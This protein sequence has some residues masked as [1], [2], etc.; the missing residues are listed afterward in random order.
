MEN[1]KT[2][3]KE[4]SLSGIGLHTGNKVNIKFKPAGIDSGIN[5][6]RV[7]LPKKENIL[8]VADNLL[9]ISRN[10]RRTSIG[11]GDVEI[12]TIEHIMAV[13]F[14][15]S[16]DNINIEIDNNEVP[17]LDGSGQDFLEILTN[18]GIVEQAKPRNVYQIKEAICI[19]EDGSS[20][21][22][23]PSSG[24]KVSYTLKYS[25]PKIDTQFLDL[26]INTESFQKEL[27]KSRT[28]CL[29]EEAEDLKQQG[30]GRGANYE[31]TLVVGKNGV[32]KNKLRYE[33][34]YVRHKV[35]DLIGDLYLMGSSLKGHIV[36]LR[37]GH[38]LNIKLLG[39]IIEQRA[40]FNIG[41]VGSSG[42][43]VKEGELDAEEIKKILPHRYPFL[44]VDKILHLEKGKRA[45]GLKNV[46]EDDYYF[47]GHFPGKPVMP[48][49]LIIEAMAQV[50]GVMMLSLAQNKG[51]LAYFLA[52][53]NVKFRKTVLPG[54]KLVLEVEVGKLKSKTGLVHSRALVGSKVVAEADLM[55]AIAES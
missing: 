12:H 20:I 15:L 2:I 19:E 14:G 50:G 3:T 25:H 30:L 34:E 1:Q 36:A 17:G 51:K 7:D 44:F 35:L 37:S 10:P 6:I 33:D 46:N 54:D 38:S 9:P 18:A 24:F 42:D 39:K 13:L 47:K 48:G 23:L 45:V 55:F 53:N 31:N 29:E 4:V 11:R 49:V 8:A 22:A 40:R 28:F 26:N 41:G 5:F 16:I 27:V 52:A 32:I 43:Y 21:I